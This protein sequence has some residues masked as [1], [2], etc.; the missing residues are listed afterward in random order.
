MEYLGD[1]ARILVNNSNKK[2]SAGK[3]TL[4]FYLLVLVKTQT[5]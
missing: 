5:I 2:K 3:Q 4:L 1:I